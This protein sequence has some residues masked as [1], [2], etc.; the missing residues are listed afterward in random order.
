MFHSI[1]R[2]LHWAGGY[3][4][5]LYLGCLCSF[6]SVWCTA[7]PIV[8]AA[9]TLGLVIAD[10]RGENSLEWNI[11]WLSLVGIVISIFLRYIFS[12][13]KAKLQESIG[14]EIAAEERL[15]IGNVLKR[16]SLGYFSKNSTGDILTAITGDLSSL[17]LQ[18]M[19]L[20]DAIVNGYINLLAIVIILL[21]VCPMA[22]LTSLVGAILSALALNGISKKSRK[23]APAKQISQ[24]R[25]TDASLEYIH[26]LPIVKSFGQEGAS[27]EEWKTACEKHKNINL[28]IMHGFVPNNCLHLLALKIASV[29]LIL[30]SGI[31][32]I[33]GNLTISIFL[34][35][36][37]FA[38]MIFG[39]V[40]NM[41]DSVHMLGL[42]DTS[43]DK[44]ENIEN[45]EFIDEAGRDFSIASYNIDFTDVSFGYG[46]IEV[47]HNLSFQ[48]PQNTTTA[49]V[50]PSGSGKST[51][52]NLITRFYDVNSGSVKIGGHDVREFTCDSLL[53]NI[54][55]VF[56]NVY[57][58]NDTIRNNIK[59]GKSD[60]TEDEIIEAAKKACCHDFIMALPEGYDT[61]IG[62][63]GSSLSGGEKQRISIARAILKNAPIILLDEATASIDPENEHLIQQAISELIQGKT[64]VTIAHR[65]ATIENADQILV[66]DHG[67]IVQKGTHDQL[68][69]KKGIYRSFI[70]IRERAEGWSIV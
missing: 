15:K 67:K 41:N 37:M 50:G 53:K 57:L 18:G 64:I 48:I 27:I 62:E 56:Q 51:I 14:Y 29:L 16:V 5:R 20:I 25:I 42:I 55:M 24:E 31:F 4:K 32:T 39:A 47:L 9:W 63:G 66:V 21:I 60:A 43:M 23:N 44:L 13:W 1:K 3:R 59:F 49:I 28:K 7:I 61:M 10:F 46:E 65:L 52:C 22:A 68:I 70:N 8:I 12:Y 34:L 11:I 69:Q 6:F 40:E 58:F 30:I 54:S 2:L 36:A 33:Q 35:I 45:A 19:K 17:E 26:G 38:F